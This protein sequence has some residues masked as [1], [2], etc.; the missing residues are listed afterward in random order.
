MNGLTVIESKA[1]ARISEYCC[2]IEQAERHAGLAHDERELADLA[3][4]GCHHQ[5]GAGRPRE[6]Q[7]Q[8]RCST[9]LPTTIS[10]VSARTGPTLANR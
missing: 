8:Q 1:P 6:Q 10:A 2:P 7:S 3:E 4:P 9:A 5:H